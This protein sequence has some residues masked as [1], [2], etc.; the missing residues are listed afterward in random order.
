MV[1]LFCKILF[2]CTFIFLAVENYCF[3]KA[4]GDE[5]PL[6][7]LSLEELM[8][9]E[10][11]SASKSFEP[12]Q[13]IPA[14]IT[15][16]TRSEIEKFGYVT[17]EEIL[18]NIPG[19]YLLDNTESLFIGI[20]GNASGGV[21]VLINGI[22]W[23]PSLAKG[24]HSTEINQFNIPVESIDRIEIIRGPM[25]V[26]YGNN[27]FL[28][29]INV[30]TNNINSEKSIAS[31]SVGNNGVKKAF[32]RVAKETENGF[33][34]LNTGC[35]ETDGLTGLF[36]EMLDS[37]QLEDLP[38][39]AVKSIAGQVPKKEDSFDCSL[40]YKKFKANFRYNKSDYGFYPT[41]VSLGGKNNIYMTTI[42]G[43]LIYETE[44]TN[45]T[46][47][48]MTSILSREKYY[49]P[50][51]SLLTPTTVGNQKQTS[52]RSE[53]EL[54]IIHKEDKFEFMAG[55]RY[56]LV[57]DLSNRFFLQMY[58]DSPP[59]SDFY[60]N[61]DAVKTN[62][63]FAQLLYKFNSRLS[64][65]S[66]IRY[67]RLPEMYS[68]FVTYNSLNMSEYLETPIEDR[69]QFTGRV[70]LI[71]SLN[72]NNVIKFMVGSAAQDRDEFA[73]SEPEEITTYEISH[74][75][76]FDDFQLNSSVFYSNTDRIIQRSIV[77]D[78]SSGS[79]IDKSDNSGQ[80]KTFGIEMSG[81]YKVND[82]LVIKGSVSAQKTEDRNFSVEVG[83]SPN[84]LAKLQCEYSFGKYNVA[85]NGYYVGSMKTGY[86]LIDEDNNAGTTSIA[87]RMGYDV[88]G[89]FNLGLNFRYTYDTGFYLNFNG[90]NILDKKFH[91]PANEIANMEK[92]LI[93][94][95]RIV[96]V[97]A[98]YK[99]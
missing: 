85:A 7:Q 70:A 12:M 22:P 75:I 72:D 28:G 71:Y 24:L 14:N 99:F 78:Q 19:M 56:K 61:I 80:W 66:G 90:S 41:T 34:V 25:S 35:Y 3:G 86:D 47:F 44:V 91:Y 2:F 43:S 97:T 16:I 68:M 36:S 5:K 9:V 93:G 4:I 74:A 89:Y 94:Q 59:L 92:G 38:D 13:N 57:D 77:I 8:N 65:I 52:R 29:T 62:E 10:V 84:L 1:K 21:Q 48:R 67:L 50:E 96:V 87:T 46:K 17:F 82:Y 40:N 51:M 69:N 27:A 11:F 32:I 20:R 26:I 55:Y 33:F 6:Y 60:K 53:V 42:H 63:L 15:I 64:L 81:W 45:K 23:H 73:F 37:T 98:G 88:G 49:V 30:I 18:K 76:T 39:E 95:G 54:N 83:Y 79:L 58:P 31:V